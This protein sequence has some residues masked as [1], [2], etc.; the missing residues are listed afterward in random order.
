MKKLK[1][2]VTN[3]LGRSRDGVG[4][5]LSSALWKN[6]QM[7]SHSWQ[8]SLG[9]GV[10]GMSLNSGGALSDRNVLCSFRFIW[11]GVGGALGII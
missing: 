11:A 3:L 8:A 6:L 4:S 10:A 7:F 2:K 5:A 1:P 9:L